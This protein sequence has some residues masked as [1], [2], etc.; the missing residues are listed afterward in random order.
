MCLHN[1]SHGLCGIATAFHVIDHADEWQQ[2]IKLFHYHSKKNLYLKEA[3]RA[4]FSNADT[5]SA[6]MLIKSIHR[7]FSFPEECIPFHS[8]EKP[9]NIGSVVGWLGFPYLEH[10]TLCFFSG[11]VSACKES[12]YLIDG[13]AI[14]GVSGGPVFCISGNDIRIIGTVSAYRADIVRGETSPGLM[15]ANDVSYFHSQIHNIETMEEA[16][17]KVKP[18]QR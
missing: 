11:N 17:Q 3:D 7:E 10:D 18:E 12:S 14:H 15:Y 4:I 5:D 9:L 8:T 16:K 6:I 2:P 1:A 13:V